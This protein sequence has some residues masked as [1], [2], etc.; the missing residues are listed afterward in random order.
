N[1]PLD[2]QSLSYNTVTAFAEN[3]NGDLWIA[4]GGGGLNLK[5]KGEEVFN[6]FNPEPGKPTAVSSWGLLALCQSKKNDFLWIGTY[7]SGLDR[8]DPKTNTFK[9]Y[10][11]GDAANQLNNDAVYA[12]M[13]DSR[14]HIW[15]GTNGGGVNIRDPETGVI[16][17][18]VQDYNSRDG[19]SGDYVRAFC[20]DKEGA[21]WIGTT[22]GLCTY[23]PRSGK[24]IPFDPDFIKLHSNIIISLYADKA[25]NIWIGTIGGGL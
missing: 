9:N 12:L 8:Y 13:E 10:P 3:K 23:Y 19:L 18:I 15:I 17:K 14:G 11:K 21:V 6:R 20:E 5:R 4:T 24:I 1:N 25:D 7:G 22:F 16:K 2:W